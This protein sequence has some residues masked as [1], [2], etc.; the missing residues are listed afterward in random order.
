MQ[1]PD[2][3]KLSGKKV[4]GVGV[5][6]SSRTMHF[7][8]VYNQGRTQDIHTDTISWNKCVQNALKGKITKQRTVHECSMHRAHEKATEAFRRAVAPDVVCFK[9]DHTGC[10]KDTNLHVD[11][12]FENGMRFDDMLDS[13]LGQQ[14]TLRKD[15]AVHKVCVG[16]KFTQ[17][18]H[19]VLSNNDLAQDWIAYHATHARL[20]IL[21]AN[22][23][24][25]GNRGFKVKQRKL[26]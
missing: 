4:L 9:R 12:D 19:Y 14:N 5:D 1:H 24:L 23:N 15:V 17:W 25:Q 22:D 10:T 26:M 16:N 7:H 6:Q 3:T 13:F 21:P 2:T 20:R 8:Y 11:H 18:P